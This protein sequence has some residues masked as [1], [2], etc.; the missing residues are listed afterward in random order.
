VGVGVGIGDEAGAVRRITGSAPFE[1]PPKLFELPGVLVGTEGKFE[2]LADGN[3]KEACSGERVV[4]V[5]GRV[6]AK[7]GVGDTTCPGAD[8]VP[9]IP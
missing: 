3:N 2:S 4:V 6:S 5:G 9:L 7:E 1:F 8:G